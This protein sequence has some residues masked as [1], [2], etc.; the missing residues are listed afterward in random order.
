MTTRPLDTAAFIGKLLA[1]LPDGETPVADKRYL[2][3]LR[4]SLARA[5]RHASLKMYIAKGYREGAMLARAY[6]LEFGSC[7]KAADAEFALRDANFMAAVHDMML[8][9][10]ASK[11][12]LKL[13]M[14][15][16]KFDGGRPAWDAAIAR[17]EE[18]FARLDE[19]GV[20]S[21]RQ[22]HG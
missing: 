17:D 1:P 2:L 21:R 13:K 14:S 10:A 8:T 3:D 20:G 7:K 11:D 22:A 19:A 18:F 4:K 15:C 6:A 16:R 12:N 9:P 5:W